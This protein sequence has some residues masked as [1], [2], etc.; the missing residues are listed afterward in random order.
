MPNRRRRRGG[1]VLLGL[2]S[3]QVIAAPVGACAQP[4]VGHDAAGQAGIAVEMTMS[5]SVDHGRVL[6]ADEPEASA[7]PGGAQ[8]DLG[9]E[10]DSM[11]M[12]CLALAA[13]GAAAV[14]SVSAASILVLPGDFARTAVVVGERPAAV[15]LGL[16]TPPPKI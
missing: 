7:P 9:H 15:V 1:T 10:T 14:R 2:L 13:C 16:V 6:P 4:H 3:L 12:D 11:P 5:R 8:S